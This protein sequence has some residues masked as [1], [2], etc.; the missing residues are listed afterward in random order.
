M[1]ELTVRKMQMRKQFSQIRNDIPETDAKHL[2]YDTCQYA[3]TLIRQENWKQV[4]VY[5]PFRSELNL[6]PLIEWCWDQHIAIIV[7]KCVVA[8]HTM[9]LYPL[10]NKE[11]LSVGAYHILEPDSAQLK[12]IDIVPDA[13]IVPGLAFTNN[14]AR[15]GYGGGYYD[16][17]YEAMQ[18]Q[19][20]KISWVGIGFDNQITDYIPMDNYDISL[21]IV[22]TNKG[23]KRCS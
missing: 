5:V 3:I 13:V 10:Y 11:Q 2:S 21:N 19:S 7:P 16:R 4:M 20:K 22:V 1:Q 17:F 23:I 18:A 9:Q 8:T 15:L 14:G 12:P 6:W